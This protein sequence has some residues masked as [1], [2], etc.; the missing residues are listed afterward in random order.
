VLKPAKTLEERIREL[1]VQTEALKR[2][3]EDERLHELV[4]ARDEAAAKAAHAVKTAQRAAEAAVTARNDA[5]EARR[6]LVAHLRD[7]HAQGVSLSVLASQT[8]VAPKL[9]TSSTDDAE[10]E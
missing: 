9:I 3:A 6:A 5:R 1:E 2:V 7:L 8:G 10:D 4:R